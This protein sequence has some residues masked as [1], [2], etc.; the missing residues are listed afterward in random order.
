MNPDY[1]EAS[2]S[3]DL[4]YLATADQ[5]VLQQ[6]VFIIEHNGGFF[7]AVAVLGYNPDDADTEEEKEGV[8]RV[9]EIFDRELQNNGRRAAPIEGRWDRI[10]MQHTS[11][12]KPKA[13]PRPPPQGPERPEG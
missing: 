7:V 3:E 6:P 11:P 13:P 1:P 2:G 10:A 4:G 8:R 5:V 12:P 9:Q